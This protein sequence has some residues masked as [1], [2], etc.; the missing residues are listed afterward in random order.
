MKKKSRWAGYDL[1]KRKRLS[2]P[3]TDAIGGVLDKYRVRGNVRES[4]AVQAWAS[5]VGDRIAA[6]AW[7]HRIADGTIVVAVESSSWLH[8]LSF[9]KDDIIAQ[10]N[11]AA[12]GALVSAVRF[13]LAGRISRHGGPKRGVVRPRLRRI[14]KRP[15]ASSTPAHQRAIEKDAEAVEDD[16]LRA[17]IE[18]TRKRWD[19]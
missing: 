7:P 15:P 13:E 2:M 4:R 14:V 18:R 17:I 19:L 11:K 16:E 8:Q 10:I 3:V 6:R 5:I 1:D 12:G 9:M